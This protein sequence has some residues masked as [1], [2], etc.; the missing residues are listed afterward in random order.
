MTRKNTPRVNVFICR[1]QGYH[2]G[3]QTVVKQGLEDADLLI[4]ALGSS[5][6][7]RDLY[8][9]WTADERESIIRMDSEGVKLAPLASRLQF[10]HLDDYMYND[11][12][13]EQHVQQKIRDKV[14]DNFGPTEVDIRLIGL[15]K[16]GTSYYLKKFP[17]WGSVAVKPTEDCLTPQGRVLISA[18]LV[19]NLYFDHGVIPFQVLPSST[20]A[21]M[22]EFMKTD[23]YEH[24]LEEH[25]FNE[26]HKKPYK[27]LKYG[28]ID[29]AVDA[30]VIQSGHVLMV[31]RGIMPG[32]GLT[33][34]PGG[35]MEE[36]E[37][38]ESAVLRELVQETQIRFTEKDKPDIAERILKGSFRF[39]RRFADPY[40][41]MRGR[42]ITEAFLFNLESRE[43]L[44]WIRGGSDAKRAF[45][46]PLAEV[47]PR[48]CFEDHYFIIQEMV[49]GINSN[50]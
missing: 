47:D 25:K 28:H 4:V 15:D 17:Q 5:N 32:R 35:Y 41:S 16:D 45:W 6:R 38:F 8:N 14:Y 21:F 24:L 26:R 2:I 50:R 7:S 13:W 49:R 40:R 46:M 48:R 22:D 9:P 11:P 19:R 37:D 23:T 44:P 31:E 29:Q 27:G 30:V 10:V 33:A 18:T 43:N 1:A 12:L 20:V 36:Y 39:S 3:H 34:L 42:I